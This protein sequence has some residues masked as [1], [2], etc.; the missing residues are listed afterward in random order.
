MPA[1]RPHLDRDLKRKQILD[2]AEKLFLRDG[3]DATAMAAVAQR[4]G[5]A[6]NAVYWYFPSKDDLLAAMLERRL[7]RSLAKF[8]DAETATLEEQVLTML[9]ML[10]EVANLTAAVHERARHST[11]VA[12]MHAAFHLAVDRF[13][14]GLF[15]EA[16]LGPSDAGRA[17]KVLMGLVEGIHLH[18]YD[19]DTMARNELVLWTIA[20]LVPESS[21]SVK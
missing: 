16:G 4:A 18:E 12:E 13:L 6:N 21:V 1:T 15:Q 8:A 3:Y 14:E 9:A 20:R 7:E 11:A 17:A 5:V 19:R 2:A 10:D